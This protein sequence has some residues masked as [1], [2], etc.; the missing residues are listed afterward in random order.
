MKLKLAFILLVV[1][2][3][4][5]AVDLEVRLFSNLHIHQLTVIPDTGLYHLVAM[6]SKMRPIDTIYDVFAQDSIRKL[7]FKRS[8]RDVLLSRSSQ[9]LGYF[10]TLRLVSAHPKKE[11]RIQVGKRKRVYHGNLQVRVHRGEL[12]LV[13]IVDVESYVGGVVESEGGHVKELEYFKAQAVLARTFALKNINK[14]RSEGYGL[15]D[16]VTSQVYF[17]R[18]RYQNKAR[19]DS[20]VFLTKD[21]VIVQQDCLPILGVFH[22]NS[23]G[24]TTNAEDAWLTSVSYLKA[25]EDSFSVGVG[26]YSWERKVSKKD[27]YSYVANRMKVSNDILLHKALLNLNRSGRESSFRF[28]KRK[29]KL[30]NFRKRYKLRSTYFTVNDAGDYLI[31]KGKGYG[32]GV[33]LSQDG[34]IEMSRRGY[35]YRDILYFYFDSIEL[36]CIEFANIS[37]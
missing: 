2:L 16:D 15:K 18:S 26:S 9:K 34:A 3:K 29:L 25:R 24:V 37:P 31:L 36:E 27:F 28:K 22:A 4:L 7:Y 14:H 13:N 30:T 32:H 1:S 21:T 12:Q 20:A 19:I 33:G 10:K 5:G 23:G 11:F 17:S 35:N 6:D 8:G